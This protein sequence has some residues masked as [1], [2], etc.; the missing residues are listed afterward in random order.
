MSPA[1]MA[2]DHRLEHNIIFTIGFVAMVSVV[3][4]V[5]YRIID[6]SAYVRLEHDAAATCSAK[7]GQMVPDPHHLAL[8]WDHGSLTLGPDTR[9]TVCSRVP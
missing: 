3:G 6:H 7:G 4:Y 5:A 9:R 1:P 2:S 8:V